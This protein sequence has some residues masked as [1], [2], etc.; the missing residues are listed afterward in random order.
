MLTAIVLLIAGCL[1]VTGATLCSFA[2][3]GPQETLGGVIIMVGMLAG[4]VAGL[5]WWA[6]L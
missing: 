2:K 1:L 4:M 6:G 3:S 5:C